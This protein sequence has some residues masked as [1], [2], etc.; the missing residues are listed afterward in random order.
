MELLQTQMEQVALRLVQGLI[1][2]ANS[3]WNSLLDPLGQQLRI[4]T[5]EHQLASIPA[6]RQVLAHQEAK[7]WVAMA[8]ALREQ[9][10]PTL[11][12]DL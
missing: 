1:G 11:R 12:G 5:K 3:L 9:L 2:S 8:D 10:I 7:D 6:L 4:Q